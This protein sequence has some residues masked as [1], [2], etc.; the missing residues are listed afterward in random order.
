MIKICWSLFLLLLLAG[1]CP[2]RRETESWYLEIDFICEHTPVKD[3]GKSGAGWIYA[4]LSLIESNRIRS[5]DSLNLSA[6]FL[7]QKAY[8]TCALNYLS[9]ARSE[10]FSMHASGM[11]FF[12]LIDK[13]GAVPYFVGEDDPTIPFD[14]LNRAITD[15]G[16]RVSRREM[17]SG[18]AG[19][20]VC[21]SMDFLF[22][23]IPERTFLYGV[24]YSPQD[25]AR[26]VC[27]PNE[28]E[29]LT[30][31]IRF[32]YGKNITLSGKQVYKNLPLAGFM[33]SIKSTLRRGYTLAWEGD[34]TEQ[35]FS[36]FRGVADWRGKGDIRAKFRQREFD[37]GKTT[38]D[39][40]MHLVGMAHNAAGEI[41][42]VA[43]NSMGERGPMK[44]YMFLSERYIQLKTIAVYRLKPQYMC[45]GDKSY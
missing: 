24:S 42:F 29:A 26:S 2:D 28:Y 10:D 22:N 25:L 14:S 32:P 20:T 18:D 33:D 7:V 43:K 3:Q 27:R 19:Q 38:S 6:S 4:M 35:G 40:L 37:R 1:C 31:F 16:R 39:H 11:R 15:L 5:G 23:Y 41:F 21:L 9:Q 13:Y 17:S 34:T 12:S 30:S 45:I 44:G 8:K 36:F